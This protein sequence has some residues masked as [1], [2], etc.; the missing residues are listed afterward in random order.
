MHPLTTVRPEPYVWVSWITKLLAGESS[1]VW[2]AWLRA[3]YQTAKAPNGFDM[4]AW[5]MDHSAMLRRTASEHEGEGCKV[6]TEGQNLF[7]L[8][9]K[10][11]TLSG[12]PDV[13]AIKAKAAAKRSSRTSGGAVRKAVKL[14]IIGIYKL[15]TAEYPVYITP[16]LQAARQIVRAGGDI[17]AIDATHRARPE[18]K[19]PEELIA[20]IQTKLGA[21][22][23]ADID[24]LE[25]GIADHL[26]PAVRPSP[27]L[28]ARLPGRD[29][30][31][32][33]GALAA[34]PRHR[35]APSRPE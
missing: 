20:A 3:H 30:A 31:A 12:K 24:S 19:S 4:G 18:G 17:I 13:V 8:K 23:M 25:E 33:P 6:F 14:P 11:G 27:S 7:A 26:V 34:R 16:T 32:R 35:R 10:V 21:P 9:G 1:C 29:V 15:R 5:Q 22:V 28:D 2:S